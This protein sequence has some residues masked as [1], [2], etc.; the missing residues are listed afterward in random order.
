MYGTSTG[1]LDVYQALETFVPGNLMWS[2]TGDHGN[3][4]LQGQVALESAQNY[5]VSVRLS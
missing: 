1:R 3:A 4:W 2:V 5:S